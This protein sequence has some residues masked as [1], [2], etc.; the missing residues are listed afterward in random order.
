MTKERIVLYTLAGVMIV[1]LLY[2]LSITSELNTVL[3]SIN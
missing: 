1:G 3:D 2:T